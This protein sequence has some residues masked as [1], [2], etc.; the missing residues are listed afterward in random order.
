DPSHAVAQ[1]RAR[2]ELLIDWCARF[3][4]LKRAQG[5]RDSTIQVYQEKL[6]AVL[7][8]LGG[9]TEAGVRSLRLSDVTP[10]AVDAYVAR[11]RASGVRSLTVL[12][13]LSALVGVM[14]AAW[15]SGAYA[16]DPAK[17]RPVDLS[18]D[19]VPRERALTL[20][21]VAAL[22]PELSAVQAAIVRRSVAFGL[23]L[24][25]ALALDPP[26]HVDLARGSVL[27][28][29]TTAAGARRTVPILAP[30]RP[31]AE[32]IARESG[33][34]GERPNNLYRD[35]AAACRRAGIP[36]CTPND[37]RRSH[38]TILAE[39][40]GDAEALRRLL[41]HTTTAMVDRVYA[42][43]RAQALGEQ[44]ARQYRHETVASATDSHRPL[45]ILVRV[46]RMAQGGNG[47]EIGAAFRIRTGDL[48]FT[49][50][51]VTRDSV[52]RWSCPTT[53]ARTRSNA[54]VA[55]EDLAWALSL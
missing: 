40:G 39:G 16:L 32:Q 55:P 11:R 10:D 28:P 52:A 38:A 50:P 43:P 27:V 14:R 45:S 41:G 7:R 12:K 23:R 20:D 13:E 25:E 15:R 37:L 34:L 29:G 31:L 49:K 35:L 36:R 42:R 33:P 51:L 6:A 3:I 44:I 46:W 26:R 2:S 53:G 18:S 17:L 5:K 21:E 4:E 54:N 30:F 24:S 8:G 1:E 22:L 47:W 48:R 19:Y 9:T